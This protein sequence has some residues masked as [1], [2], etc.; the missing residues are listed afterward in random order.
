MSRMGKDRGEVRTGSDA[1]EPRRRELQS[2]REL[3]P[4][5][6]GA[7]FERAFVDALRDILVHE[8]DRHIA[9]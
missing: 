9:A 2:R 5:I 8:R 7:D 4:A 3:A 6:E 1:R